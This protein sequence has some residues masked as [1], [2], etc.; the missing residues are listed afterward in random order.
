MHTSRTNDTRQNMASQ[1]ECCRQKVGWELKGRKSLKA[2][3]I[4]KYF[5][6]L[7]L[8]KSVLVHELKA[9]PGVL[10]RTV[11]SPGRETGR[12]TELGRKQENRQKISCESHIRE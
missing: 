7:P 4:K 3:G 11:D 6:K 12:E 5:Q 8:R 9:K 1:C 2:V 10:S